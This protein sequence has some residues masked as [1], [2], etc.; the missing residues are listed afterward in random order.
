MSLPR[1][2]DKKTIVQN[3]QMFTEDDEEE[4]VKKGVSEAQMREWIAVYIKEIDKID[5]F[6]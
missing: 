5:E 1:K 4:L 6:Y 3:N 2:L